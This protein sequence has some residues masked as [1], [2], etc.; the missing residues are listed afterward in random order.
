M[1]FQGSVLSDS[2]LGV[3]TP[4]RYDNT[5][6]VYFYANLSSTEPRAINS[7]D[8]LGLTRMATVPAGLRTEPSGVVDDSN[9]INVPYLPDT[10]YG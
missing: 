1:V 3:T 7:D 10:L 2:V 5:G 9:S 4:G 8:Q 6:G